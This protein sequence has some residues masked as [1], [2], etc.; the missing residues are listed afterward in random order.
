MA[1]AG[2]PAKAEFLDLPGFEKA[3]DDADSFR[4]PTGD[5]SVEPIARARARQDRQASAGGQVDPMNFGAHA[6]SNER[7][8]GA[9][10]QS[11]QNVS[12]ETFWYEWGQ[13]PYKA[14]YIRRPLDE[15]D[16]AESGAFGC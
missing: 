1:K 2:F 8:C 7:R 16:R 6:C 3:H 9:N 14:S 5:L 12:R 10:N 13:K 15:W 11:Y 4:S